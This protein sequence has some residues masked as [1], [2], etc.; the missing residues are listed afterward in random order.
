[1]HLIKSFKHSHLETDASYYPNSAP[2]RDKPNE[3]EEEEE[4]MRQTTGG[5]GE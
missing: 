3:E 4:E 1:M 2:E 5:K